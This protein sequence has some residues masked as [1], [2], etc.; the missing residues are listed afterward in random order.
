M[1]D[2]AYWVALRKIPG[3]GPKRFQALLDHFGRVEEVWKAG[4]SE[5]ARVPG[6]GPRLVESFIQHRAGIVPEREMEALR[7]QQVEVLTLEDPQYP[8]SLRNIYDP[9]PVL[10]LKGKIEPADEKAIA[11]VGS[12]RA[13]PYGKAVAEQLAGALAQAGL[14]VVSGLARGIDSIAHRGALQVGG[15]TIAVLGCGVDVVYP[16]ENQKLYQAIEKQG[17]IIS[18]FPLGTPPEALNFPARNRIISGLSRGVVVIEAAEDGGALITADFALE[19][20]RDVFAVPGPVTSRYS[21]GP[22]RLIKEGARLVESAA[23]I[24]SE[25]GWE[26]E[27]LPAELTGGSQLKAH[28]SPLE[29]K[30]LEHLS[31]EPRAIETVSEEVGQPAAAVSAQLMLLEIKGLVNR[32]PGGKYILARGCRTK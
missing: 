23:D 2:R 21:A 9:P 15:R 12:R 26:G 22:N 29:Q 18:E 5:L 25:Y 17:A 13:T 4:P 6:L 20:G 31:L 11:V 10:F 30:L 32:L 24:L 8:A 27:P 28:L 1:E 7:R 14:C 19:Q 16:R 3:L